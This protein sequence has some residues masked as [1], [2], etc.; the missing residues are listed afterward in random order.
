[1]PLQGVLLIQYPMILVR[2]R[3]KSRRRA[4]QLESMESGQ[5]IRDRAAVVFVAVDDKHW[6]LPVGEEIGPSRI[7]AF[8]AL[9]VFPEHRRA[10]EFVRVVDVIGLQHKGGDVEDAVVADHGFEL[11]S[12]EV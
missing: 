11:S 3:E 10:T 7:V 9:E 2:E 6:C 1:M 5:A 4:Q 8:E 12:E